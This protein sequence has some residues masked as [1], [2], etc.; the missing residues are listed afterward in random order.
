MSDPYVPTSV[1]PPVPV[2]KSINLPYLLGSTSPEQ[3]STSPKPF[4]TV[5]VYGYKGYTDGLGVPNTGNVYVGFG[6][7]RQPDLL[8]PGSQLTYKSDPHDKLSLESM[9]VQ[10]AVGDGVQCEYCV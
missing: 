9:W 10:G 1:H 3:V 6:P 7:D 5:V 4:S 8:P 2:D